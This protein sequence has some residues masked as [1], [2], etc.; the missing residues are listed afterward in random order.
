M[1]ICKIL[2]V[3]WAR[4]RQKSGRFQVHIAKTAGRHDL[5]KWNVLPM[6]FPFTVLSLFGHV[7]AVTV[8]K[9]M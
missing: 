1:L 5:G 8:W 2:Q 9:I 3:P 7:T 4:G 6:L